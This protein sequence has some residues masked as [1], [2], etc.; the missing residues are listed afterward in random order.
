MHSFEDLGFEIGGG[1]CRR[2]RWGRRWFPGSTSLFLVSSF[3][4]IS[5]VF[6]RGGQPFGLPQSGHVGHFDFFC[7]CRQQHVTANRAIR[8]RNRL[9][10]PPAFLLL[11]EV[12]VAE[13][14]FGLHKV[15]VSL[16][17]GVEL[18]TTE[19]DDASL[20]A[21]YFLVHC[22]RLCGERLGFQLGVVLG[23][24]YLDCS[25]RHWL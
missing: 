7:V 5:G 25:S 15:V 11:L 12:T 19:V 20:E 10:K 8:E 6:Q 2:V 14:H 16:N 4:G 9:I 24:C 22:L 17:G 18:L 23:V 13:D 3:F 1:E 21:F